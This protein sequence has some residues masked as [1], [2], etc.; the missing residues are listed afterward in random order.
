[1]KTNIRKIGNS[2]GAI[3]PAA[4]LKQLKLSEG[5]GVD[6]FASEGNIVIKPLKERPRYS[7]DE[8]LAQ[9]DES[10]ELPE[11]LKAWD[12]AKPVGNEIW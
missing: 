4:I 3:L 7:L 1:M 8:L 6:I 10:S 11:E 9:C 5:D 2:S 12:E